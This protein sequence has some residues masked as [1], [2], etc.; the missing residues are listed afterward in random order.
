MPPLLLPFPCKN[1]GRRVRREERNLKV[2]VSLFCTLE[3]CLRTATLGHIIGPKAHEEFK[4]YECPNLKADGRR[5]TI[6]QVNFVQWTKANCRD[7]HSFGEI[8]RRTLF[9]FRRRFESYSNQENKNPTGRVFVS[10]I[11]Y[12]IRTG[13]AAV[14]GRCPRPL[15]EGDF[16]HSVE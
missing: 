12:R 13:A 8:H 7:S 9:A 6:K 14:K 2:I 5:R 11:P 15:D 3:R 16:L 10:C 1:L 4:T